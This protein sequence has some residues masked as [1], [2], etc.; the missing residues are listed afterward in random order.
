MVCMQS[1]FTG[2]RL[3][4]V[5]SGAFL[6][7]SGMQTWELQINSKQNQRLVSEVLF[8]KVAVLIKEFRVRGHLSF[9]FWMTNYPVTM[10]VNLFSSCRNKMW[11]FVVSARFVTPQ[12]GSGE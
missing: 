7:D 11:L 12:E 6:K 8:G 3:E 4:S 10:Y 1:R 5:S 2:N 9:Y